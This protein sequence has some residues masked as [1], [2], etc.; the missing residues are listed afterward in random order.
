MSPCLVAPLAAAT[1]SL[2][3]PGS[4]W[5]RFGRTAAALDYCREGDTLVV[6]KL[7]RLARSG[8]TYRNW[9]TSWKRRAWR[10]A[11][12]TLAEVRSTLVEQPD[13]V[14]LQVGLQF[15]QK[16]FLAQK[17]QSVATNATQHRVHHSG[18]EYTMDGIQDGTQH[19]HQEDQ[20]PAQPAL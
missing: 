17:I 20:A 19:G 5:T 8:D 3:N 18:S 7:D 14:G 12:S 1:A 13:A 10:S 16:V 4:V 2:T 9:W 15:V 6:T 11:S